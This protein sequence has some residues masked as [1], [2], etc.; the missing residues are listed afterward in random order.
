MIL[1]PLRSFLGALK[2]PGPV[3]LVLGRRLASG[4]RPELDLESGSTL[5][6]ASS[7]FTTASCPSSAA[8]DSG[9]RPYSVA[10][11]GTAASNRSHWLGRVCL[12]R[13][14][15]P[16]TLTIRPL[17]LRPTPALSGI[18]RVSPVRP[19]DLHSLTRLAHSRLVD[20]PRVDD[21]VDMPGSL[22][23]PCVS[24]WTRR[25]LGSQSDWLLGTLCVSLREC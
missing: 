5:S 25:C 1:G 7:S 21:D 18:R 4:V 3:Q 23:G 8:R 20:W 13:A 16:D 14:E 24:V 12:L 19:P 22:L 6:F 10:T 11:P 2:L 15:H 9:V 17:R